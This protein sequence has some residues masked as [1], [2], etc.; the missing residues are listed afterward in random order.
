M[1][2]FEDIDVGFVT[3]LGPR[4]ITLDD[5]IR[6]CSEFDKLPIHLDSE[7]AKNSMYGGLIASGLHT[8]S[9]SASIVVDGFLVGTSMT[10]ASGMNDVRWFRPVMLPNNISVRFSVLDKL[11]PKP[12]RNFGSIK[13]KL[14]SL[15]SDNDVVMCADVNYLFK[16]RCA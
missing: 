9:V 14:E 6:F 16:S 11:Q 12:G 10:G 2:Y 4:T 13:C 3:I 8:L 7:F 1:Q 15:N 5:S